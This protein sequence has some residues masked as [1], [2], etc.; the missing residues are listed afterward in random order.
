MCKAGRVVA[1]GRIF[2]EMESGSTDCIGSI[3]AV[4][5][6]EEDLAAVAI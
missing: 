2:E 1:G 6:A 3:I 4:S 5:V